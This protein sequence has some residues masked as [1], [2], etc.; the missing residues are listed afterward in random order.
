MLGFLSAKLGP[1][2]TKTERKKERKKGGGK[3]DISAGRKRDMWEITGLSSMMPFQ[4]QCMQ[5][6]ETVQHVCPLTL[7]GTVVALP[8]RQAAGEKNAWNGF[9]GCGVPKDNTIWLN[10]MLQPRNMPSAERHN[11]D[12]VLQ[13]IAPDYTA[14]AHNGLL[15]S[16]CCLPLLCLTQ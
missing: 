8:G 2:S 11:G 15:F 5:D 1:V 12:S 7:F 10:Q 14:T 6:R 13:R 16:K 3:N 4:F 9:E